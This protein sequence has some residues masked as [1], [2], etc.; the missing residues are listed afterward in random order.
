M[1]RLLFALVAGLWVAQ[2]CFAAS[3]RDDASIKAR[4]HSLLAKNCARCHAI[5]RT[6][7]STHHEAPAFRTLAQRYPIDSLAE[8]LAEGFVTGHPDMPEFVFEIRD[9][10]AILAYL[11]SIQDSTPL[12]ARKNR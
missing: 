10:D 2:T 1:H 5:D 3:A 7:S 12:P 6:G 8:A 9:V 11:R 4:G